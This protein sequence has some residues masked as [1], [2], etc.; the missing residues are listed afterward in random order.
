MTVFHS[1][2]LCAPPYLWYR[3]PCPGTCG[4]TLV[5]R[6]SSNSCS[7]WDP[8]QTTAAQVSL[9]CSL[10]YSINN[11]QNWRQIFCHCFS[12]KKKKQH[13]SNRLLIDYTK[14]QSNTC[15]LFYTNKKSYLN[16]F[17]NLAV[18]WVSK[19]FGL[20]NRKV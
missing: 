2:S 7:W 18:F 19:H 9:S 10:F 20:N 5:T 16:L 17:I 11:L 12:K 4:G 3:F 6:P 15:I 13:S 14:Y 1:L 8:G